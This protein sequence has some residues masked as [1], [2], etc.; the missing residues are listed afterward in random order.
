M[1]VYIIGNKLDYECF[2]T[3]GVCKTLESAKQV[4][5]DKIKD[6][7]ETRYKNNCRFTY[8]T[9]LWNNEDLQCEDY[10]YAISIWQHEIDNDEHDCWYETFYIQEKAF[11]D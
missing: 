2:E 6:L 5:S 7:F 3:L 4:L 9:K 1:K 8:F 10:E 11:L